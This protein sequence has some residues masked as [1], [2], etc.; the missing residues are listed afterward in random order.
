MWVVVAVAGAF[1]LCCGGP[2]LFAVLATTALG[3]TLAHRATPLAA[4]AGLLAVLAVGIIVGPRRRS[5]K[6][7]VENG[8]HGGA[9]GSSRS[10]VRQDSL[11]HGIAPVE[12]SPVDSDLGAPGRRDG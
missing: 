1:A 6:R 8:G 12:G 7:G 3:A 10:G 11:S 9:C 4:V 5:C 2:A